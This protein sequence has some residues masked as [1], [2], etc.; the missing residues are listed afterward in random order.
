[1]R[2]LA[3]LI[4]LVALSIGAAHGQE[5]TLI[6]A[7]HKAPVTGAYPGLCLLVGEGPGAPWRP[8]PGGIEGF[9]YE[10]GFRYTLA[11]AEERIE[12]TGGTT[13]RLVRE[14]ER[15]DERSGYAF[16]IPLTAARVV[17]APQGT[18]YI[19]GEKQFAFAEGVDGVAFARALGAGARL[20]CR[21][22]FPAEAAA[23]LLLLEW[24][25][26]GAAPPAAAP[27]GS[28]V[29]TSDAPPLIREGRTLVPLRAIFEW[30]GADVD[31]DSTTRRIEATK[32]AH[33]VRLQL[34]SARA[35][36]DGASVALEAPATSISGR[37]YVPLR[38]VSEALGAEVDWD[39]DS[40]TVTVQDGGRTG[41]LSVP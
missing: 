30:L 6:V 18:F 32:G 41:T 28:G 15:R 16:E 1:M 26:V 22:T 20:N 33:V 14:V 24:Q 17:P 12:G 11:V 36:V 37:A 38:F 9:A 23:P 27:G 40:R 4:S 31:Y 19:C 34:D 13:L 7:P 10:W 5:R 29:I 2:A 35:Y 21:L 3:Q 8:L 25:P 39:A